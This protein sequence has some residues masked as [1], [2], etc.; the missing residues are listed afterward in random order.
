MTDLPTVTTSDLRRYCI[1]QD[2]TAYIVDEVAVDG[3]TAWRGSGSHPRRMFDLIDDIPGYGAWR[4]RPGPPVDERR[5][6]S[7]CELVDIE[8]RDLDDDY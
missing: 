3:V 8:G 6:L 2:L 7:G 5:W 1:T 4:Y